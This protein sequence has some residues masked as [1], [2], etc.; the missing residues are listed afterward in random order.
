MRSTLTTLFVTAM[1]S[2]S[3]HAAKIGGS[4]DMSVEADNIVNFAAGDTIYARQDINTIY[5]N[6][7]VEGDVT[8]TL[9]ADNIVNFAAGS[10][11]TACQS[12]NVVGQYDCAFR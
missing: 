4:I 7:E 3:V 9:S 6:A 10:D 12:I 2:T 11:V 8:M 1:L 5:D